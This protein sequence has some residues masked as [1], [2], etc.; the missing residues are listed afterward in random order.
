V[1]QSKKVPKPVKAGN[2]E[3]MSEGNVDQVASWDD[4]LEEEYGG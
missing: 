4:Q 3:L 1:S 2:S